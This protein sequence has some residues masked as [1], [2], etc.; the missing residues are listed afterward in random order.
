MEKFIALIL[1][2]GFGLV[3]MLGL[4]T[5]NI[6]TIPVAFFIFGS[7]VAVKMLCVFGVAAISLPIADTCL[8]NSKGSK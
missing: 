2:L 6:F 5:C 8:Q 1:G 3:A 4:L 7:G